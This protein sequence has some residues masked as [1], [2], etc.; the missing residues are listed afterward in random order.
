MTAE[1]NHWLYRV[2]RMKEMLRMLLKIKDIEEAEDA[3]KR[4]L[5]WTS[6]SR[7]GAFKDLYLKIKR[8]IRNAYGFRKSSNFSTSFC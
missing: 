6:H 3:F 1:N 5:W 2:C 7:I 4:W 8:S